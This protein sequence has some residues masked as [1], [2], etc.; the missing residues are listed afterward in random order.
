[1][2]PY[3]QTTILTYYQIPGRRSTMLVQLPHLGSITLVLRWFIK[4]L[5]LLLVVSTN[6]LASMATSNDPKATS[7]LLPLVFL[8]VQLA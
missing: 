3:V 4:V 5:Q 8:A 6:I 1:M 2:V 7:P